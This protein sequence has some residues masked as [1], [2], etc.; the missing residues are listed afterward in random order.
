MVG[1]V[2][3]KGHAVLGQWKRMS[4]H[5][6]YLLGIVYV[7]LQGSEKIISAIFLGM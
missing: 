2:F 3:D 4:F 5:C 6:L 1:E 7:Y